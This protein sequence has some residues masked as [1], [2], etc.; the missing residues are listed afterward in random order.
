MMRMATCMVVSALSPLQHVSCA[1]CPRMQTVLVCCA[2][3]DIAVVPFLVL[4]PLFENGGLSQMQV[5]A[6]VVMLAMDV[7]C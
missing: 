5:R 3:Q 1:L 7:L 2:A 4:L 6:V